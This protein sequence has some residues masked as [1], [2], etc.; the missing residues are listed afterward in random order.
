MRLNLEFLAAL[1]ALLLLGAAV[2]FW[3]AGNPQVAHPGVPTYSGPALRHLEAHV[4]QVGPFESFYVN[5]DNPFIPFHLRG[6]ERRARGPRT[7]APPPAPPVLRPR[8]PVTVVEPQTPVAKLPRL[9]P[10]AATAPQCTGLLRSDEGTVLMVRMPAGTTSQLVV[11]GSVDGWKLIAIDNDNVA[12]FTDPDGQEETFPI[13]E[14]DVTIA[15]GGDAPA[16]PA[17]VKAPAP[18][19]GP[20]KSGALL[21]TGP[22]MP[23]KAAPNG[24]TPPKRPH[25]PPP[26][27]GP[28]P[29]Q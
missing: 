27:Q 6:P 11:G 23:P 9:T 10:A 29:Q 8:G 19:N 7:V 15:Q 26:P 28:V 3:L 4:P 21:P 16:T 12:R 14:G 22:Q 24:A 17:P 20:P 5:E 18:K 2:V 13:G 1:A 25:R